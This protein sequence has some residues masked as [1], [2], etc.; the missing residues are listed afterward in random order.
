[1]GQDLSHIRI[2]NAN[3]FAGLQTLPDKSVHAC[4]TSPPYWGLRDYGLPET[5]WP[6]DGWRGQIGLEASPQQFITHMVAVFREVWRV[7]RDDGTLWVN[8]GDSYYNYRPGIKDDARATGI[9]RSRGFSNN[10]RQTPSQSG[11][12]SQRI[13]GLK[14][15][16]RVGI[17]HMLAF[18]L[19]D[20]GWF[21]RDE[22]VWRK[23]NTMPSSVK[24][25]CTMQHEFIFMFAKRRKYFYDNIAIEEL[26]SPNTHSHGSN[27]TPAGW[28]TGDGGH[29]K[30]KGRYQAKKQGASTP[31]SPT[32]NRRSVWTMTTRGY[33]GTHFATFCE[34][35]P[36][37]AIL[38]A[39]SMKGV[40]P[41]CGAPWRR[42]VVK[43]DKLTAWQRACGAD[44]A[45]RY[46]GAATKD[47]G[48]GGA[49]D[50]SEV[51]ARILE[52]MRQKKTVGWEPTCKH[53]HATTAA[54]T[55]LDPFGGVA[56]TALAAGRLER[57]A[58]MIE[59]SPHS[60][61]EGANRVSVDA[62]LTNIVEVIK[63]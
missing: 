33:K 54:A 32:R 5:T 22:I 15:K 63:L 34:E 42:M 28:D 19:R 3:V 14:E 36:T 35:L 48:S 49:Q 56:T 17:P 37:N 2:I 18:A 6:P 29:R 4:V 20:D 11:K 41:T 53:K 16:D 61:K 1:V 50:P 30:L 51:K 7:L 45:G 23:P 10:T 24:D 46:F 57:D 31:E 8:M 25:R 12:R 60:A 55:V 27:P 62:T 47:Y 58:V 38:A 59:L 52:G 40:C 21:W 43:G 39:T 26:A 44:A 9:N 13:G